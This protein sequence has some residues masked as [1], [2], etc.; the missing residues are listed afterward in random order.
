MR[1]ARRLLTNLTQ[2][3]SRPV[4]RAPSR[5]QP[6]LRCS[7]VCLRW[8]S[9]G[10]AALRSEA[11]P[12]ANV[13]LPDRQPCAGAAEEEGRRRRQASTHTNFISV[14][15]VAILPPHFTLPQGLALR[16]KLVVRHTRRAGC[17]WRRAMATAGPDR[18]RLDKARRIWTVPNMICIARIAATPALCWWIASGSVLAVP[19]LWAGYLCMFMW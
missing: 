14:V 17:F 15:G 5:R 6:E 8:K 18:E 3:R 11:P 10:L 4:L 13:A 9:E 1:G 2:I 12:L 16:A 7:P 19:C